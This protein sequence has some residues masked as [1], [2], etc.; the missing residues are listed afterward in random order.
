LLSAGEA[1]ED[2][3]FVGLTRLPGPG[4]EV[5][6]DQFSATIGGGAVIT[7]VA[8]ARL[9][10]D[11]T[12]A[13]GLSDAAVRRLRAER[14]RVANLRKPGEPHAVTAALS[15][16]GERAFVTF[17][18][19]NTRLAPRLARVLTTTRASHVHLALYPRDTAAWA[20]RVAAL[21]R[22][23]ITSSWD[24]G[25]NDVLARDPGLPALIDALDIVFVNA[26]EAALYAAE[27]RWEDA[28]HFWRTRRP[29]TVI[30]LGANGCIAL[31]R[32]EEIAAPPPRVKVVDTTGA[33]DAFNGGFLAAWLRGV[34]LRRCLIAGNRMGAASTRKMGGID[35]LP[36]RIRE[37]A[38]A[39]KPARTERP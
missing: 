24:F 29:I 31:G 21:R 14:V 6:T 33:G 19:M 27:S 38:T 5:R 30:K 7:A 34:P 12:L 15:T 20:R 36:P 4:E 2:L 39:S 13:S 1:F 35:A 28:I 16:G 37:R 9:G 26:G 11:V 8:A 18:G 10:L 3:V 17:D 22:R 23:G 32:D 25:W